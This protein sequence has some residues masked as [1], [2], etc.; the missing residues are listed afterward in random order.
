MTSPFQDLTPP[1]FGT[2]VAAG[3]IHNVLTRTVERGNFQNWLGSGGS[4]TIEHGLLQ[5]RRSVQSSEGTFPVG[6]GVVKPGSKIL[7][8]VGRQA[9]WISPVLAFWISSEPFTTTLALPSSPNDGFLVGLLE[10]E[11]ETET[12]LA[13]QRVVKR[14]RPVP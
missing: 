5:L 9:G 1:V 3:P 4:L 12:F 13:V 11:S 10:T 7:D 2:W 8:A 6:L 14:T